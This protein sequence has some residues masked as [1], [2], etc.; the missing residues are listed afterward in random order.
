MSTY[1]SDLEEPWT[2]IRAEDN[3]RHAYITLWENGANAGFLV[4]NSENM[5]EAIRSFCRSESV[6]QRVS[7]ENDK[8]RLKIFKKPRSQVI[9]SEY[10]DIVNFNQM[11]GEYAE[12]GWPIDGI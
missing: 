2:S 6:C 5:H 8:L 11:L 3:G 7:F 12:K 1:Y 10:G 4:I 9:V